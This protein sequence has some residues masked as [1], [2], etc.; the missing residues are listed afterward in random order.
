MSATQQVV[1]GVKYDVT[2]HAGFTAC[3]KAS[4]SPAV[5][6]DDEACPLLADSIHSYEVVIWVRVW[7]PESERVQIVSVTTLDATS[8]TP[9]PSSKGHLSK[10][11][12]NGM[13][14]QSEA[15]VEPRPLNADDAVVA[16]DPVLTETPVT[17]PTTV[18]GGDSSKWVCNCPPALVVYACSLEQYRAIVEG[19]D[20]AFYRTNAPPSPPATPTPLPAPGS[21][22]P[23]P[24][25]EKE[26]EWREKL[27][28]EEGVH[29]S[30][31]AGGGD[32]GAL[33]REQEGKSRSSSETLVGEAERGGRWHWFWWLCL[34][35]AMTYGTYK[36][37]L[38]YC[39]VVPAF[40]LGA[41]T[42]ILPKALSRRLGLLS[43]YD[44]VPLQDYQNGKV[45]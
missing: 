45:L 43:D 12:S 7:L 6:S 8:E 18:A 33:I 37:T 3:P 17:Q 24:L 4:T 26:I 27:A 21:D 13:H 22:I 39:P 38:R 16:A 40:V 23:P 32:D 10:L 35:T 19:K 2:L 31:E 25:T 15:V 30:T 34:L 29:E 44:T 42:A 20:C 9:S 41:L 28:K 36:C 5:L 11:K 14:V 1:A